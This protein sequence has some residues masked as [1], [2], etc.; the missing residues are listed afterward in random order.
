MSELIVVGISDYKI[1]QA[2]N[3]LVTYA[4]GSCVGTSILDESTK[5]GGLSHIMLPD[6]TMVNKEP[7]K[8]MAFADTALVDMVEAMVRK[9]AN[10]NTMKAKIAGGANMFE[11]Q[12]SSAFGNIGD[13]NAQSVK[14]TLRALNIPIIGEDTGANYGRSVFFE[15]GTGIFR[16]KSIGKKITEL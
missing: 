10:R 16:I 2:P 7:V 5:I 1:S 8:R 4:L 12:G 11:A 15:P 9:G 14:E 6:S 3:T 13:R